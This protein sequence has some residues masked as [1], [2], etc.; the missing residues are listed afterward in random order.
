M[1]ILFAA[2]L[3]HAC[4]THIEFSLHKPDAKFV[5]FFEREKRV[6]K[7]SRRLSFAQVC[8]AQARIAALTFYAGCCE[9]DA[10]RDF[11]PLRARPCLDLSAE[12]A[13]CR[14]PFLKKPC[15]CV[16][17]ILWA[18]GDSVWTPH[19]MHSSISRIDRIDQL[20]D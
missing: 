14:M 18:A 1:K 11:A 8:D 4:F 10:S 12:N 15:N 7:F 19:A 6:W 9:R 16:A 5:R 17:D 3:Q 20:L 13:A 2:E